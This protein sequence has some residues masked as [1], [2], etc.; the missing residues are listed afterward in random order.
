MRLSSRISGLYNNHYMKRIK[1]VRFPMAENTS[2]VFFGQ[3]V[4]KQAL[5]FAGSDYSGFG[6]LDQHYADFSDYPVWFQ[7][8]YT[9][10]NNRCEPIEFDFN[11]MDLTGSNKERIK[12]PS[13][14]IDEVDLIK[15]LTFLAGVKHG[16]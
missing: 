12:A 9:A 4:D 7:C 15:A 16:A 10:D 2:K 8:H 1:T 14:P 6:T 3:S 11:L 5:S 13:T